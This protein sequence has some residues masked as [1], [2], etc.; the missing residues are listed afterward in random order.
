MDVSKCYRWTLKKFN[1]WI[2]Q[3]RTHEEHPGCLQGTMEEGLEI[4]DG[5]E[6]STEAKAHQEFLQEYKFQPEGEEVDRLIAQEDGDEA[7]ENVILDE[8]QVE[9]DSM[10]GDM[11][12]LED[13][14][15]AFE[16]DRN[17]GEEESEEDEELGSEESDEEDYDDDDVYEEDLL[18]C[19]VR[20][21][22]PEPPM[23]RCWNCDKFYHRACLDNMTDKQWNDLAFAPVWA[24][25]TCESTKG[26]R[27]TALTSPPWRKK[28]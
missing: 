5:K 10:E 6:G 12:G 18:C 24:C 4:L 21:L 2:E 26:R 13:R 20:G 1:E 16:E 3:D 17:E 14:S 8:L 22:P 27:S 23:L 11:D 9:H 7:E 19:A 25:A 15:S 28:R